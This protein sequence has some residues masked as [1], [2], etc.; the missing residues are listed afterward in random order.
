[1]IRRTTIAVAA[2]FVGAAL[3]APSAYA[4][5]RAETIC[6]KA[7]R[8]RARTKISQCRSDAQ[9]QQTS[10]I[11]TCLNDTSNCVIGCLADQSSCQKAPNDI[12]AACKTDPVTGCKKANSDAVT[13][14]GND[15]DP[16]ACVDKAQLQLF[17]CNQA[18]AAQIEASLITCNGNFSDCLQTCSNSSA[19]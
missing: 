9:T 10:E 3:L 4:F 11:Q 2:G 16:I 8:V 15:P 18:C 14:C 7:A 17:L 1:M 12:L 13:A 19:P 6:V 5:T